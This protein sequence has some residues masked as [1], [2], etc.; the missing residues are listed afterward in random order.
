LTIKEAIGL[1]AS[2]SN[3]VFC[4]YKFWNEIEERCVVPEAD[5][6]NFK[7]NKLSLHS[8][9]SFLNGVTIKFNHSEE[10]IIKRNDFIDFCTDSSLAIEVW[11]HHNIT[12]IIPTLEKDLFI[13][14][15]AN[16]IESWQ[17]VRKSLK[18]WVDIVELDKNGQWVSVNI[19]Q[20]KKNHTGGVY[21]LKQG[22]SKRIRIRIEDKSIYR[23]LLPLYIEDFSA[24]EIGCVQQIN[25][26]NDTSTLDSYQEVDL[27]NIRQ[28]W[29]HYLDERKAYIE[30]EW[31]L[32]M[33]KQDKN[34]I[35]VERE[36]YLSDQLVELLE[37]RNLVETPPPNSHL[38]GS[39]L[40]WKP[41]NGMEA[42]IPI[43]YLDANKINNDSISFDSDYDDKIKETSGNNCLLI[44]EEAEN[45]YFILPIINK[46]I[47]NFIEAI[48][49]WDSTIHEDNSLNLVT[50]S[51]NFVYLVVKVKLK[52]IQPIETE[53]YMRK[54][55][56]V[57]IYDPNNVSLTN[58]KNNVTRSL[59]SFFNNV[60]TN[61]TGS[62]ASLLGKESSSESSSI[63]STG[64]TYYIISNIPR[65]LEDYE[66]YDNLAIIAAINNNASSNLME[67]YLERYLNCIKIVDNL[68]END[69]KQ[70]ELA[71]QQ[72]IRNEEGQKQHDSGGGSKLSLLRLST[73]NL[74]NPNLKKTISVP[75]LL[76]SKSLK[77]GST[78][79]ISQKLTHS[80]SSHSANKASQ[81]VVVKIQTTPVIMNQAEPKIFGARQPTKKLQVNNLASKFDKLTKPA[82]IKTQIIEPVVVTKEIV[83]PIKEIVEIVEDVKPVVNI[84]IE[85]IEEETNEKEVKIE[86]P[87]QIS[88]SNSETSL[89]S[90]E[91]EKLPDWIKENA[92]VIVKTNTVM[93]KPGHVRFIGE[94]KF[95]KGIWIGVELDRPHGLNDGSCKGDRYFQCEQNKGVFVK[96]DKLTLYKLQTD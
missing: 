73:T 6:E 60:T 1:P 89:L 62:Q 57:Q 41:D 33:Q 37:E 76:N 51:D 43:I 82:V 52:L 28:K 78:H 59:R 38:P 27:I 86:E 67:K 68:L 5:D 63:T 4:Q 55:I 64:V 71:L 30:S 85:K 88:N 69:R 58:V 24:I 72:A 70:Q 19:K 12:D 18:L 29:L 77:F 96:A 14:K 54:R 81:D 35:D 42:N 46:S 8:K 26:Q 95:Q 31:N 94:V 79:N 49:I 92:Y 25:L 36:K 50:P 13:S 11:G 17:Q 91:T 32:L 34:I 16:L 39:L 75:N 83:E 80:A 7:Q 15:Y 3:F 20:N 2:L 23:D 65:F 45:E 9:L 56:C 87:S 93:N 22:T 66:Q 74:N 21:Q 40:N 53:I 48:A 84:K 10:H 47:T 44:D 61:I 90:N